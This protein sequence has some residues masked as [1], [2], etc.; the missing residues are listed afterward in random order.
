MTGTFADDKGFSG[1]LGGNA[2][3]VL[4]VAHK[5]TEH[6]QKESNRDILPMM[7]VILQYRH[8]MC[9]LVGVVLLSSSG[10]AAAR[11]WSSCCYDC[12]VRRCQA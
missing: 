7:P 5:S 1:S 3:V 4:P 10:R 11:S 8:C 12:Q 2:R 6:T 9:E